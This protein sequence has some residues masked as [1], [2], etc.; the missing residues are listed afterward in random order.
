[1]LLAEDDDGVREFVAEVLR[2][3][4]WG[5]ATAASP[6]EALAT[7]ARQSLAIDL[8]ITD[9]VMPGMS[10]GELADRLAELRPGL[11]VLYITGY[12]DEE[13]GTRGLLAPGRECLSKPFTPAQLRARVRALLTPTP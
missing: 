2:A 3:S 13:V 6:A 5:V 9:V 11:R 1:V 4:G 12:D 8:L 7:A 10:G